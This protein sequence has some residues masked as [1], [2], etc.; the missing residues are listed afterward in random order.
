MST[1]PSTRILAEEYLARE[2]Q[3]ESKSEYH[4]GEVFAMGGA[5]QSHNLIVVNLLTEIRS[6]LKRK[7]CRVYPSDMRLKV[8]ATGMYAYPDVMALC[9]TPQLE[10]DRQDTLRN[11][12]LIIEVLSD[13]TEAYD[14]GRK[15]AQY[16]KI[17]S[18]QEY[19][20]LAQ[21]RC[22]AEL[23]ARQPDGRWVL[24]E[25]ADSLDSVLELRSIQCSLALAEVYDLVLEE[26][27]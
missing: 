1:Q 14:R 20:M 18:L 3:S 5:S 12:G 6:Q 17:D 25:E 4:Q 26:A 24:Q 27:E 16:R 2:R 9:G 13:S 10:D 7:P 8:E 22:K 19:L 15:F 23:Y 11:P 21:D